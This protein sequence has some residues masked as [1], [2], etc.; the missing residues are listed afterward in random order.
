M[1][2]GGRAD[3]RGRVERDVRP[4]APAARLAEEIG[5]AAR[6]RG[7]AR[8]LVLDL[9][10]TLAPIVPRPRDARVPRAVLDALARL[11]GRGWR[12]AIVTGRPAA[13]ARRMV[14]LSGLAIFG[15]HGLEVDGGSSGSQ[16]HHEAAR[17]ATSIAREARELIRAFPGASVESKPFGCAFHHR[18]LS[19]ATRTRFKRELEAW[20]A[21]R[22]TRG[23]E[24]LLGNGVIEL[25]PSGS[26]KAL[27]LDR[28]PPAR[29]ARRGDRS[30]VAIG[31]DRAD[32]ELF[33]AL[34]G[35]G[36]TVRVGSRRLRSIARRR[37]SGTPAVA[38]L[39][40]T[41]AADGETKRDHGPG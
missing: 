27:V 4:K 17:R 13:M 18:A 29:A 14:P 34:N 28:W 38:R 6:R 9:D 3:A 30:F 12:V 31:D 21:L 39:L 5:R 36:L 32:E 24:R 26:G 37:I 41:L 11:W 2:L 1:P 7:A 15:S 33:A 19:R 25:R 23:L 40:T 8:V 16:A 10:G 20:L 22:D 35:R